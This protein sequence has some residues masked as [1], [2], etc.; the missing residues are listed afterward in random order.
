MLSCGEMG[1]VNACRLMMPCRTRSEAFAKVQKAEVDGLTVRG[2]RWRASPNPIM[3]T[4][5][6]SYLFP[7]SLLND[8][9]L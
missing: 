4:S 1:I 9:G 6:L 2:V 5:I 3:L 7:S 8:P